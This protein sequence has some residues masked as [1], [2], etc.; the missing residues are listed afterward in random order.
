MVIVWNSGV[1]IFILFLS[2]DCVLLD[3]SVS[4]ATHTDIEPSHTYKI[5]IS[6]FFPSRCESA[7][8]VSYLQLTWRQHCKFEDLR[9][10]EI[11][12]HCFRCHLRTHF[13]GWC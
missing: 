1:I 4:F 10:F 8:L 12:F 2:S 11:Q 3:L 6:L 7:A 13:T 9:E 5:D